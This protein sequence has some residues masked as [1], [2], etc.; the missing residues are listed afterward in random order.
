MRD[1]ESLVQ[2][3]MAHISAETAWSGESQQRIQVGTIDIDLASGIVN[4]VA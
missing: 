2:V 3:E 4:Q 1:A